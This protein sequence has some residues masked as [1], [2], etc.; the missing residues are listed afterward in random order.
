MKTLI[1][2]FILLSACA[3]QAKMFPPVPNDPLRVSMPWVANEPW[4]AT[5]MM[6]PILPVTTGSQTV[7]WIL[8]YDEV[9]Q[10]TVA[11]NN[12]SMTVSASVQVSM[13]KPSDSPCSA[14]DG[15]W[16]YLYGVNN[17]SLTLCQLTPSVMDCI[18][19]PN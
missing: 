6:P 3:P 17:S 8:A 5:D 2:A 1:V 19:F 10:S 13:N 12:G 11:F 14:Y 15:M 7:T 9:C 18:T 4:L 16:T